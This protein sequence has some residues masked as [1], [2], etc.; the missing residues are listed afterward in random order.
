[1]IG[2]IPQNRDESFIGRRYTVLAA[3]ASCAT[4]ASSSLGNKGQ[5]AA[6]R[7]TRASKQQPGKQGPASSSPGNMGHQAAARETRASKQQP[8]KQGPASSSPGNKGQQAA[9]RETRASKR[10]KVAFSPGAVSVVPGASSTLGWSDFHFLAI[11]E[12]GHI[13]IDWLYFYEFN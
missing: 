4:A 11:F 8:G 5:Q 12:N 9:A 13:A 7:E 10:Q 6:A 2:G 1:M 3:G